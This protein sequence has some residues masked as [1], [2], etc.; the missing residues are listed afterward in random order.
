MPLKDI[1][2]TRVH[3]YYWKYDYCCAVTSLKMLNELFKAEINTQVLSAAA[4]L[5]AGR[6]RLQCGLVQGPLMFIGIYYKE[7]QLEPDEISHI[8]HEYIN[9]FQNEFSSIECKELRPQGFSSDN[10]PHLCE[11]ITKNAVYFAAE[12]IYKTNDEHN[13]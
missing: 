2:S 13:L 1:I 10:P 3:E 6:N 5:S 8:C 4:G 9:A 12:F 11:Q 7:K